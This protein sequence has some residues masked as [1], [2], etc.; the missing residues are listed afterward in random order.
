MDTVSN[1]KKMQRK[2]IKI[3]YPDELLYVN[4]GG[5][6]T[7]FRT[8]NFQLNDVQVGTVIVRH[9]GVATETTTMHD[10][11]QQIDH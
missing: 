11:V 2:L 7:L 6:Y 4:L 9:Q 3:S 1:F 10:I 8:F 5:I